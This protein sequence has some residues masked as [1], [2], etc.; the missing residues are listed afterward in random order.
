MTLIPACGQHFIKIGGCHFPSHM[1][2]FI[3]MYEMYVC[4][5]AWIHRI[6]VGTLRCWTS[7]SE[8]S[9]F[10]FIWLP[11]GNANPGYPNPG[12]P[13]FPAFLETRNPGFNAIE[14]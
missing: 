7:I 3:Y 2:A 1:F 11:L 9:L 12:N 10:L 4:M 14:T 5:H 6:S 8:P 13:G